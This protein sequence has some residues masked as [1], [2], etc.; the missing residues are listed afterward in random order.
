MRFIKLNPKA[1]APYITVAINRQIAEGIFPE[2]MKAAKVLPILKPGKD[3]FKKVKGKSTTTARAVVEHNIEDGYHR[4]W[5]SLQ[6]AQI[7]Q[8]LT[9][10]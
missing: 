3:S 6:R 5:L 8:Q 9:T 7:S 10:Q 4:G 2:N 1:L